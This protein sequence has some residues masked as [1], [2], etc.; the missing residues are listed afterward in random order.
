MGTLLLREGAIVGLAGLCEDGESH[1]GDAA[2]Q[3]RKHDKDGGLQAPAAQVGQY[4]AQYSPPR[5]P[6]FR[7]ILTSWP[8]AGVGA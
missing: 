2:G 5:P 7:L 6:S 8:A 3:Q 4:L 1:G